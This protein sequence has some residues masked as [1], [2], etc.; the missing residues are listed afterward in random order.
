[1]G[2]QAHEHHRAAEAVSATKGAGEEVSGKE[3]TQRWRA[4]IAAGRVVYQVEAD[5]VNTEALL[6]GFH[7]T[8]VGEL[9]DLLTAL[10]VELVA[11]HGTS[12]GSVVLYVMN[13]MTTEETED[14]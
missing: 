12:L 7:L 1:M 3:R 13:E 5:E 2:I 14:A 9:L 4:R 10:D 6:E 8:T 11:R